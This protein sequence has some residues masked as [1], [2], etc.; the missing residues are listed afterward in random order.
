MSRALVLGAGGQLGQCLRLLEPEGHEAFYASR[1]DCDLSRKADI[2]A[3]VQRL[4]PDYVFNCAAY[5]QV[6]QAQK[7][8]T[9]AKRLNAEAPGWLAEALARRAPIMPI[10]TSD[11]PTPAPRP[12]Y[13][14]LDCASL[15]RLT[16]RAQAPWRENLTR[17]LREPGA[18][19]SLAGSS[20]LP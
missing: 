10:P 12:A 17:M 14:V 8:R 15:V 1:K 2:K 13:S 6:D 3:L 9:L 18:T 16:G 19:S 11:Y 20:S 5:T 7:E 4:A